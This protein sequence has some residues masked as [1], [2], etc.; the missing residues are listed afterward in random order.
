MSHGSLALVLAATLLAAA[1]SGCAATAGSADEASVPRL[2]AAEA[3]PRL[4]DLV[5]GRTVFFTRRLGDGGETVAFSF[6]PDEVTSRGRL[7]G[8]LAYEGRGGSGVVPGVAGTL[9]FA[10]AGEAGCGRLTLALEETTL[11]SLGVRA[12][13]EPVAVDLSRAGRA[14]RAAAALCEEA[15][16][17]VARLRDLGGSLGDLVPQD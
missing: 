11:D 14:G 4:A 10:R 17:L 8:T 12:R 1:S 2:V 13:F 5:Q 9:G 7:I 15:R 16:D 6:T 3:V